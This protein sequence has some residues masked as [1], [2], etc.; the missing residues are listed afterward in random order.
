MPLQNIICRKQ[1]VNHPATACASCVAPRVGTNQDV[2]RRGSEEGRGLAKKITAVVNEVLSEE[3]SAGPKSLGQ[4]PQQQP[5]A[6]RSLPPVSLL[7]EA[8]HWRPWL[9]GW[10]LAECQ[11][12]M[13]IPLHQAPIS[14][15]SLQLACRN[16]CPRGVMSPRDR[17][18]ANRWSLRSSR[19]QGHPLGDGPLMRQ[20][21]LR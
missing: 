13:T 19:L 11:A 10:I 5:L 6:V 1:A 16:S 20:L 9:Q 18:G 12:D 3:A 17:S 7:A 8:Q 14:P 2:L 4:V 21:W 15:R